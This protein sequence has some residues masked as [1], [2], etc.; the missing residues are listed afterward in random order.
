MY[1][2]NK[3]GYKPRSFSNILVET[4]GRWV[5]AKEGN[6]GI[7]TAVINTL[8]NVSW[9]RRSLFTVHHQRKPG[10]ELTQDRDLKV[11]ADAEAWRSTASR[12]AHH[13]LLSYRTQDHHHRVGSTHNGLGSPHR[14][15][16]RKMP[17]RGILWG[18]FLN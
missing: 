14:C 11:G 8:T 6:L 9:G 12:L 4:P 13:G 3:E 18:H 10:Q 2:Q 7:T 15:P 5:T 16:I 1:Q 17:Y